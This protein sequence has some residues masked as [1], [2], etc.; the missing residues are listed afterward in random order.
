M[1]FE[2]AVELVPR[3][4]LAPVETHHQDSQRPGEAGYGDGFAARE[5]GLWVHLFDF[6]I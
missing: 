2:I 4:E 1:P 6:L 5:A 3:N